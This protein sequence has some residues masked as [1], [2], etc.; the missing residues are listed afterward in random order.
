MRVR[1][2]EE[3]EAPEDSSDAAGRRARECE[4]AASVMEMSSGA[5]QRNRS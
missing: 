3:G 2:D 4:V 5:S 1:P